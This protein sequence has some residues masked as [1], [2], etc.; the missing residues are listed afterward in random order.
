MMVSVA[1]TGSVETPNHFRWQ[2]SGVT[3]NGSPKS[4]WGMGSDDVEELAKLIAEGLGDAPELVA[5]KTTTFRQRF[6]ELHYLS[7]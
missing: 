6:T 3:S 2:A 1:V 5:P 7:P 4:P